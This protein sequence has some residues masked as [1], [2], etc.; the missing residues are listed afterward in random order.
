MAAAFAA[1]DDIHVDYL[2]S[3]READ[4]FFDMQCFEDFQLKDGLTLITSKGRVSHWKTLL[5]NHYLRFLR[6][7]Y[8]LDVSSYDLLLTDFEPITA[9]AG[10]LRR[11]PVI[12]LGHQPAFDFD[13][14]VAARDWRSAWI[15]RHFAPGSTRIGMHW[16][17]FGCPILPP[18][19]HHPQTPPDI[20]RRVANKVLVYLPFESSSDVQKVLSQVEGFEFFVYA[21]GNPTRSYGNLHLRSPSLTGFHRDLSECDAVI[22]SAGFELV[23]ECLNLGKRLLVK[24]VVC[25]MEQE[26]NALALQNLGYAEVLGAL[27]AGEIQDWLH[28]HTRAT[29]IDY[30]DVAGALADWIRH[31]DYGR[32]AL[33]KLSTA[34]W[35][36][37]QLQPLPHLAA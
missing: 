28:R 13:V 12:S 4:G 5:R 7:V 33:S 2:F 22:C 25:Q 9:W 30:P 31:G 8:T 29:A 23:S 36:Q 20:G 35:S 19:I 16:H 17:D 26:S 37:T 32:S 18:M 14:P 15:L 6:D 34:L 27:D 11:K 21:P 3:G 1:Y 24:P 10:R